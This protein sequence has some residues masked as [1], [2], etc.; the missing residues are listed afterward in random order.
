[1]IIFQALNH[2]P[3][4]KVEYL[5]N[6]SSDLYEICNLGSQV[7]ARTE[8]VNARTRDD[9]LRLELWSNILK[10]PCHLIKSFL[11]AYG[12]PE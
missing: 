5:L 6:E 1:M 11:E 4:Q 10:G 8:V 2:P 9:T 12:P 3:L 7:D